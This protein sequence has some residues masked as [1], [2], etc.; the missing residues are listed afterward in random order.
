MNRNILMVI[1]A[2]TAIILFGCD[3]DYTHGI[4][5]HNSEYIVRIDREKMR[6]K[7]RDVTISELPSDSIFSPEKY[8]IG[9]NFSSY[10]DVMD[11]LK[12]IYGAESKY[13]N[14]REYDIAKETKCFYST[15][16]DKLYR[17]FVIG[18]NS[19]I[20]LIGIEGGI[21]FNDFYPEYKKRNMYT[22]IREELP[23]VYDGGTI[24]YYKID[25]HIYRCEFTHVGH[26]SISIENIEIIE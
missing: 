24:K 2:F 12:N 20:T 23:S 18:S 4:K 16:N 13:D 22:I 5:A 14:Q 6:V 9:K 7:N 11:Y 3:S 1:F 15:G 8:D 10:T 25:E 26:L 19:I 21:D 17:T